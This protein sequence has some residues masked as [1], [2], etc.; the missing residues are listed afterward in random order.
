MGFELIMVFDSELD[1]TVRS[2]V[3]LV[4][5]DFYGLFVDEGSDE[6]LELVFKDL[7]VTLFK[8]DFCKFFEDICKEIV[9]RVVLFLAAC[10]AVSVL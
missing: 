6:V 4:F 3:C 7:S 8:H 5:V 10:V 2:L 1:H 9:M